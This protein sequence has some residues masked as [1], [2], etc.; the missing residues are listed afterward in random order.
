MSVCT[1]DYPVLLGERLAWGTQSS[2]RSRKEAARQVSHGDAVFSAPGGVGN[3]VHRIDEA[4]IISEVADGEQ[5]LLKYG[6]LNPAGCRL[7]A[8]ASLPS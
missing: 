2:D 4:I 7:D 3:C 8:G 6:W 1:M 5:V